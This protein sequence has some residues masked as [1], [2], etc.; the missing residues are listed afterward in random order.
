MATYK[1]ASDRAKAIHGEEPFEADLSE[2][3]EADQLSGGHLE[4]VP[5][6]YK[7]LAP[8]DGHGAGETVELALDQR[9]AATLVNFLEPEEKPAPKKRAAK[10]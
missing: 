2:T 7:V 4:I 6:P 8:W 5:S 10:K 3:E 1:P 9:R